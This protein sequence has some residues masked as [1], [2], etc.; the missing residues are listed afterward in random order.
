MKKLFGSI[1]T[2]LFLVFSLCG[3]DAVGNKDSSMAIIY[4]A[5]SIL[6]IFLLLSYCFGIKKKCPWYYLLFSSISIVNA[7]YLAL[8]VSTAVEEA[9]LANRIAYLGSAFL[10]LAML[11]IIWRACNFKTAKY[12][13]VPLLCITASAF[14][15]A[16]TPG[17]SN[18]YYKSVELISVNGITVLDKEY[19]PLHSLYM[20]YLLLYFALMLI[21]I[22]FATYKKKLK[23]KAYAII[24]LFAVLVNICVWLMEQLVSIEFE[25]LSVS[26]IVC[27]LFLLCLEFMFQSSSIQQTDIL[28]MNHTEPI[29]TV[30]PCNPDS[31]NIEPTP[32]ISQDGSDNDNNTLKPQHSSIDNITKKHN[33]DEQE[34]I[35]YFESQLIS[36]TATEQAIYDC[37]ISGK[38]TKEIMTSLDIKE[39]TLKYHNRNLYS[40][41]GVTSRKKLIEFAQKINQ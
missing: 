41:L 22:G 14:G 21:S 4:G 3:C 1:G 2:V 11:M 23:T 9:L 39:S 26:Y 12:L 6:S 35:K 5:T 15:I 40:K 30:S 20:Y 25:I 24:L 13:V 28:D 19:G 32:A 29:S 10:P 31:D 38:S 7:G 17:Y 34:K 27:G 37:Y 36:L 18:V 33:D 8:S 16:A